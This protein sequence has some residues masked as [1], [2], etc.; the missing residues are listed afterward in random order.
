LQLH[1]VAVS[2]LSVAK[3]RDEHYHNPP[4]YLVLEPEDTASRTANLQQTNTNG[5]KFQGS[6]AEFLK[7]ERIVKRWGESGRKYVPKTDYQLQLR[8][9][10]AR[11]PYRLDTNFAKMDRIVHPEIEEFKTR[12]HGSNFH[13][14]TIGEWN[15]LL[16]SGTEELVK[17]ELSRNFQIV[18]DGNPVVR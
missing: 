14:K 6:L 5:Y 2:G 13:G 17:E 15:R 1:P 12:V 3:A 4:D 11:F 10:I 7:A 8:E 9:L 18:E 16:S